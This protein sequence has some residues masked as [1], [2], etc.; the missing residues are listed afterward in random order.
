MKLLT[1]KQVSKDAFGDEGKHRL[2][3]EVATRNNLAVRW[4]RL[5]S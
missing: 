5:L 1:F 3:R 2:L 4:G